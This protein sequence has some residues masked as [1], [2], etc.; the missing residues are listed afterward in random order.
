MIDMTGPKIGRFEVLSE[1]GKGGH[2]VVYLAHD[3]QLIR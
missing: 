1:L 3:T 2:G